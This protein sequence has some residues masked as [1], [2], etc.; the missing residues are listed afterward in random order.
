MDGPSHSTN[1]VADLGHL[2]KVRLEHHPKTASVTVE[3][4]NRSGRLASTSPA[5]RKALLSPRLKGCALSSLRDLHE[6]STVSPAKHNP[7]EL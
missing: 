1:K 3:I 7:T 2:G 4:A 6:V 5:P